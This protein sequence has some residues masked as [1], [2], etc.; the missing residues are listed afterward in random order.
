MILRQEP[1][2]HEQIIPNNTEQIILILKYDHAVYK[3]TFTN[4]WELNTLTISKVKLIYED[5]KGREHT[6]ELTALLN[7]DLLILTKC[8]KFRILTNDITYITGTL[9]TKSTIEEKIRTFQETTSELHPQR[10]IYLLHTIYSLITGE[11]C[12]LPILDEDT[13]I[14]TLLH[15]FNEDQ[16]HE[17]LC[18]CHSNDKLINIILEA[19]D[20][21]EMSL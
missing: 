21:Y 19:I 16:I 12:N 1:L 5:I 18:M 13:I 2:N 10:A 17:L 7:S 4:T 11:T 20:N 15:L 6:D 14:P 8:R 9:Y 3:A